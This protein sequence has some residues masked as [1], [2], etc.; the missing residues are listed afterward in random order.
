MPGGPA[1]DADEN[2][3]K[4]LIACSVAVLGFVLVVVSLRFYI[5]LR[6]IRKAGIDDVALGV[7]LLAT[8]GNCVGVTYATR[9]GLGRH[10]DA[11]SLEERSHFLKLVYLASMGYHVIVILL[12]ATFLL[13]FRRVFPLPAFQRLCDAFM[14]FLGLWTVSGIVGGALACLP[15]SKNWDLREPIWTCN[16]RF[17]FWMVQGIIHLVSDVAIFVMPLP[18]LKTLPLPPFHKVV[19]V[20]VFCLGFLSVP[21]PSGLPGTLSTSLLV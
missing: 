13:Q 21:T 16:G 8:V 6:L 10:I 9:F 20:G 18:L 1:T 14:V 15:V 17:Y 7:T 4:S 2:L 5:R 19:L 12:K 3:A 11:L